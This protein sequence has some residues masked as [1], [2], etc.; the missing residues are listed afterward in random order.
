MAR[1]KRAAVTFWW[2]TWSPQDPPSTPCATTSRSAEAR[3]CR[4]SCSATPTT[5]CSADRAGRRVGLVEDRLISLPKV[6][7]ERGLA[8]P[9]Q[10]PIRDP[11]GSVSTEMVGFHLRRKP[12]GARRASY[13]YLPNL[14]THGRG[15]PGAPF[16][17]GSLP[18]A[19]LVAVLG[20]Q[21]DAICLGAAAGWFEWGCCMAG[22]RCGLGASRCYKLANVSVSLGTVLATQRAISPHRTCRRSGESM[23][24]G[25]PPVDPSKREYS[26]YNAEVP[27][28][29]EPFAG[30]AMNSSLRLINRVRS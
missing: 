28:P 17:V 26:V 24:S 8:F 25:I 7:S 1:W 14:K 2:T 18:T 16:L 29:F 30:D 11:F 4:R 15:I 13:V 22:R 9:V 10:V 12:K 23:G 21:F 3:W 27:V 6:G 19:S 5:G 20:G